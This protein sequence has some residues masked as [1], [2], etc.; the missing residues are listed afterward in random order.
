MLATVVL[1]AVARNRVERFGS[2]HELADA[3]RGACLAPT[4][5]AQTPVALTRTPPPAGR[6]ATPYLVGGFGAS[7]LVAAMLLARPTAPARVAPP[8]VAT[9]ALTAAPSAPARRV[10]PAPTL[11]AAPTAPPD[12]AVVS[13]SRPVRP[14][15]RAL[16]APIAAPVAAPTVQ[17]TPVRRTNGAPILGL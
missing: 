12:A 15:R 6:R 8:V 5:P 3:L 16:R 13:T 7:L 17:A 11:A 10:V 1:R 2:M 14:A 4:A 9:G